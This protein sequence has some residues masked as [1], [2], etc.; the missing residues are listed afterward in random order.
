MAHL[1]ATSLHAASDSAATLRAQAVKPLGLFWVSI[2]L[3]ISG[4]AVGVIM[5][6]QW[7]PGAANASSTRPSSLA[8]TI[9]RLEQEQA[10]LKQ[11][12]TSL[13]SQFGSA[14]GE[15]STRKA[16]LLQ[17][18]REL[19]QA[20][21]ASGAMP[22]HGPGVVARLDDSA[23]PFV[24]ADEDPSNYII[25]DY[26][27]RDIL[28]ALWIAGAEA[29]SL[30]GERITS[31]TSL[32]CVGSTIVCNVTRL[33][34]PYEIHA[35]GDPNTLADALHNSPQMAKFNLRAEIY[36]LPVKVD[37]RQDV[38]VPAHKDATV[39]KYATIEK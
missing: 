5:S 34:P 4:I 3:F 30:N 33:S 10:D 22:M 29:V 19:D 7:Q 14:Q 18:N 38:Q 35:I 26:D 11:Q 20:R 21:I 32:Y 12:V 15:A 16:N 39:F 23:A 2:A 27:L 1:F 37:Q 17:I 9:A 25:H 36:D 31:T 24:P 13:Q 6:A 8:S 28:N